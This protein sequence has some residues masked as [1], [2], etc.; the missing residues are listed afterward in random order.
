MGDEADRFSFCYESINGCT[1]ALFT[2]RPESL[3]AGGTQWM[4]LNEFSST[5]YPEDRF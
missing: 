4:A 2:T 3:D 5:M 1:S